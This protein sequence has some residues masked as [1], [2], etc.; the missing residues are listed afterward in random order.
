MRRLPRELE[1]VEFQLVP[2]LSLTND[3]WAVGFDE[4]RSPLWRWLG[5]Y[6]LLAFIACY[7]TL[8]GISI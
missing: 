6:P 4:E 7:L 1:P 3:S 8:I 5:L 2:G